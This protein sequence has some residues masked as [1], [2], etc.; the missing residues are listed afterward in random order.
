VNILTSEGWYLKINFNSNVPEIL[1]I[2]Q[3]LEEGELNKKTQSLSYIDCRYLPKV[4]Y[5]LK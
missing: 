3:K 4:Y 1:Q 5:K 2:V